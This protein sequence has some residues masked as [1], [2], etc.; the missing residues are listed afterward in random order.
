MNEKEM[1][2]QWHPPSYVP[3][4]SPLD[5]VMM[6]AGFLGERRT[7]CILRMRQRLA[8][9]YISCGGITRARNGCF[10]DLPETILQC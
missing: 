6:S 5:V 7:R 1:R 8:I 9:L 10:G 4:D 3:R 2:P